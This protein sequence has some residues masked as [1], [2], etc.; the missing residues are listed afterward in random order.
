MNLDKPLVF[1]I[2]RDHF[3]K[4]DTKHRYLRYSKLF[5]KYFDDNCYHKD[6]LILREES[7]MDGIFELLQDLS[8]H[9]ISYYGYDFDNIS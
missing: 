1:D 3:Q 9:L 7:S 6:I 5:N 8:E 2:V 4:D